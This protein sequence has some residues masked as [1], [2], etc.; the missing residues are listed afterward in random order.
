MLTLMADHD[1]EGQ[2]QVLLRVLTSAEWH[3]LWT[4]LAVHVESFASLGM[5]TH[6]PDAILWQFCQTQHII[7]ITGNRNEDGPASLEATLQV[8]N[9]PSSLPSLS[10]YS[11]AVPMR[12]GSLSGSWNISSISRIFEELGGSIS[13]SLFRRSVSRRALAFHWGR[14]KKRS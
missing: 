7:L 9:T 4:E 10:A 12:T 14:S 11:A 5:P 6:A 8:S 3:A 1:V 2:M 13:S